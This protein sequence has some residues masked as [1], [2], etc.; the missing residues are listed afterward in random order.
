MGV[1][2]TSNGRRKKRTRDG[3]ATCTA[4]LDA[5]ERL[6]S[7]KGF[8]N[9][10]LQEIGVAS[11]FSRGTPG[12]FFSS[13]QG[14]YH[15]TLER[16]FDRLRDRLAEG[17]EMAAASG[18]SPDE[19]LRAFLQAMVAGYLATPR[20]LV[21]L[22][23]WENLNDAHDLSE[24]P[25]R[26]VAINDA[27]QRLEALMSDCDTDDWDPRFVLLAIAALSWFPLAHA[28][29]LVASLGLDFGDP[30]ERD[31]YVSQ[32]ISLITRGIGQPESP[33]TA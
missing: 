22:V 28:N 29:G 17:H 30:S 13:K 23:E 6:F 8:S 31:R 19:R 10:S 20:T 5:A 14:L 24:L 11:G 21:R 25:E 4:I 9:T 18:G 12:Y 32:V 15:A 2:R 1:D 16:A 33:E 27:M 26:A 3:E 7:E